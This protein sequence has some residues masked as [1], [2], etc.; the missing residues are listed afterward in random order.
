MKQQQ[1]RAFL[2]LIALFFL[3]TVQAD[4]F[5]PTQLTLNQTLV[6]SL[7]DG[8]GPTVFFIDVTDKD[9]QPKEFKNIY[10]SVN[11]LDNRSDSVFCLGTLGGDKESDGFSW[12]KCTNGGGLEGGTHP[13]SRPGRYTVL[14]FCQNEC[15]DQSVR[16][17]ISVRLDDIL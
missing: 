4:L 3:G 2:I 17:S 14:V 12:G 1:Q 15:N 11:L 8:K 7:P 16:F 10:P 9:I 13:I 5:P 6:S